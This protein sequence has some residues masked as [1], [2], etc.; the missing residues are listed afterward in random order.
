MLFLTS[1]GDPQD[2]N[3]QSKRSGS[4]DENGRGVVDSGIDS[5]E[6]TGNINSVLRLASTF[7]SP[8]SHFCVFCM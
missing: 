2:H 3:P 1:I 6:E 4:D 8:P 5:D 7:D